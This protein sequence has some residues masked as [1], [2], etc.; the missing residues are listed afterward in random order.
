[1]K[2]S[3]LFYRIIFITVFTGFGYLTFKGLGDNVFWDDEAYT[4]LLAKNIATTGQVKGWDGKNIL[5][6]RFGEELN[7]EFINVFMPRLHLYTTA[8]SM[9][10][11]GGSTVAARLP[12][13]IFGVLSLFLLYKYVRKFILKEPYWALL[14]PLFLGLTPSF[15]LY[16]RQCRYYA[17]VVLFTTISLYLYKNIFSMRWPGRVLFILSL[18]AV[19]VSNYICLIALM[20]AL[21]AHVILFEKIG[22]DKK[23]WLSF[24]SVFVPAIIIAILI[25]HHTNPTIQFM[26]VLESGN[27]FLKKSILLFWNF[28][29]I[30]FFEWFPVVLFIGSL[31]LICTKKYLDNSLASH[32]FLIAVYIVIIALVSPQSVYIKNIAEFRS[33]IQFF[34]VV[35]KIADLRYLV[36]LFP[37]LAV[38][39]VVSIKH[40]A[41]NRISVA[42]PILLLCCL[43]NVFTLKPFTVHGWQTNFFSYIK[44]IHRDYETSYEATIGYMKNNARG[45]DMVMVWPEYMTFPI[46]YYCPDYYYCGLLPLAK[47]HFSQQALERLPDYVFIEKANPDW[48][49]CFGSHAPG[50]Q[51]YFQFLN[52]KQT[53]YRLH[54][55]LPEL[56][57]HTFGPVKKFDQ[58][59]D[60]IFIFKR[61]TIYSNGNK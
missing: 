58:N 61:I 36:G 37:L 17:E 22:F 25:F 59:K 14:V 3:K 60:G 35:T 47:S 7:D 34:P 57:H 8:I 54:A 33:L 53:H 43:T 29:D 13:A 23:K 41:R 38:V 30:N 51:N 10:L 50:L 21:V 16:I 27:W 11:F 2:N 42:L 32:V 48:I 55:V 39:A 46:M 28:R 4:A 19:F 20:F 45:N 6:W 56:P 5:G 9:K 12:H 24:L 26:H 18:V 15:Y 40:L 49:I 44:E 52:S 1:M 31:Y